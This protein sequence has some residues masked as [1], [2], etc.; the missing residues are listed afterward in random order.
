M[1]ASSIRVRVDVS[2]E[3]AREATE[4][5][6]EGEGGRRLSAEEKENEMEKEREPERA[7]ERETKKERERHA[8]PRTPTVWLLLLSYQPAHPRAYSRKR[9]S[10]WGVPSES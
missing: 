1:H 3:K 9:H 6:P 5:G 10:R 8:P 4:R 2:T 7:K